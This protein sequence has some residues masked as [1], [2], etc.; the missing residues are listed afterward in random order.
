MSADYSEGWAI[1][2]PW[3]GDLWNHFHRTRAEAIM[4]FLKDASREVY[5]EAVERAK[6]GRLSTPMHLTTAA[7]KEWPKWRR[8]GYMAVHVQMMTCDY[9][10]R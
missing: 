8:K 6:G 1:R 7:R 3:Q 10:V 4:D 2:S 9:R 5:D